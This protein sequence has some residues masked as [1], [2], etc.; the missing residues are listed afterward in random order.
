[1]NAVRPN[2]ILSPVF[3]PSILFTSIAYL[4]PKYIPTDIPTIIADANV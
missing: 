3:S 4:E 1:M 2:F